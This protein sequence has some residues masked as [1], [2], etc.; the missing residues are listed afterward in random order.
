M[1]QIRIM[2]V[3]DHAGFLRAAD[4]FLACQP[5]LQVVGVARTGPEAVAAVQQMS[6]DLVLLDWNLA[7]LSGPKVLMLLKETADAPRVIML[8]VL[9]D[10]PHYRDV[11]RALG[12][13]GFVSKADLSESLVPLIHSLFPPAPS[14]AGV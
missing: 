7:G 12:A 6:P 2:L 4:D 3:D 11:A 14:E 13:D 5:D 9:H 10:L 8:T 1:R